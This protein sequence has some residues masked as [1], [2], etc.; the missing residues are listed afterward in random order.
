MTKHKPT[1]VL[2]SNAIGDADMRQILDIL[3]SL[4]VRIETLR[5]IPFSHEPADP[6]PAIDG[7]CLAYGSSGLLALA[8][9]AG[10]APAGWD[11]EA[12]TATRVVDHFQDQALN[13]SAVRTR[14]SQ[15]PEVARAK[16]WSSVFTR[17]DS[18]T[19]E[20]A[21]KVHTIETLET[22]VQGLQSSGYLAER[23]E[24]MIVAPVQ[25]IG[26][27]WRAFVV[28]G[29][30]VAA[31]QY[32][33][34]GTPQRA[35]GAPRDVEDFVRTILQSYRPAPC[36]VIDIAE[37]RQ[38]AGTALKVIETNSINSSGFYA[39]DKRAV[40]TALTDYVT[41]LSS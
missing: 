27:E 19:K 18:E 5:V 32:A 11:G 20:F 24:A 6:L 38:A 22:F 21:G 8:H 10:W 35:A 31:S 4:D 28:D 17:P 30:L 12:F 16:G 23:D 14:W 33:K 41:A 9:R 26:A 40:L 34:D 37:V 2:Q 29:T 15:A 39:A 1:W 3:A 25:D 36:F 13:G 7:P